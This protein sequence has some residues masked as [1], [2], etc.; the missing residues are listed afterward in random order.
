MSN[1]SI[2]F[3]I[4]LDED[5]IP[6]SIVWNATDSESE[7]PSETKAISLSMWDPKDENT[8]RIDL[9]T[10]EMQIHEMKRFYIDTIGGLSQSIL[11]ATGDDFMANEMRDLCD[12]LVEHLETEMKSLPKE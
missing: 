8:L 1:K 7:K 6:E 2:K 11:S 9:W 3:D 4:G 5:N 12:R 10:K